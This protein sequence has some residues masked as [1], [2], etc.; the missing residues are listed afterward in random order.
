VAS[1]SLITAPVLEPI[2]V[3]EAKEHCRVDLTDEDALIDGYVQAARQHVETI[4][5]R[6][7]ITQQ[8]AMGLDWWPNASGRYGRAGEWGWCHWIDMPKPPLINTVPLPVAITYVDT[9]GAPQTLATTQ[10]RI[11]APSGP[12]AGRG[13]IEPAY[14]VTWPSLHGVLNNA[15]VTFWAGYGVSGDTVPRPIRQAMLLLVGHW[16]RNRESINI[17]NIVNELPQ[18][19]KSLLTPYITRS[20][21]RQ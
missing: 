19:V 13:R 8:W 1:L 5:G 20:V 3:Q 2:S 6:A 9:A 16:Y 18:A 12:T 11:D 15:T 17:G 4:T 7:L 21:Q 10:Y 14:G